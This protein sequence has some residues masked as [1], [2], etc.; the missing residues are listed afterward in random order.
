MNIKNFFTIIFIFALALIL[1]GCGPNTKFGKKYDK[2]F[3]HNAP[4]IK[5]NVKA[6]GKA[7]IAKTLELGP[8]P[9]DGDTRKL[10]KRKKISSE[11]NKNYLIIPDEYPQLKIALHFVGCRKEYKSY[12]PI[13]V[14][15]VFIST[16]SIIICKYSLPHMLIA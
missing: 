2:P 4:L 10:G 15:K 11:I 9:V 16:Y 8:K 5:G 3:K 1:S 13:L 14:Y 6:G 12:K 7:E